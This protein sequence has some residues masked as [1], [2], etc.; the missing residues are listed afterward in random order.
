MLCFRVFL[1]HYHKTWFD[2][3]L[4]SRTSHW[5]CISDNFGKIPDYL[6]QAA[7]ASK[8]WWL[9][10]NTL[11]RYGSQ[12]HFLSMKRPPT[13]TRLQLKINFYVF[14]TQAKYYEVLGMPNFRSFE[15]KWLSDL[16]C[17]MYTTFIPVVVV[18]CKVISSLN[19]DVSKSHIV[20]EVPFFVL[21][22]SENYR[23]NS[24]Y[25]T[26][27]WRITKKY[28]E[29]IQNYLSLLFEETSNMISNK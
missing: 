29:T 27:S 23:K 26:L 24:R 7:Q 25:I 4:L 17:L 8:N 22:V 16:L 21:I 12:I 5:T 9:V 14:C 15:N 10:L 1:T 3:L 18:K 13:S 6:S 11:N 20:V 19:I 2:P 28:W